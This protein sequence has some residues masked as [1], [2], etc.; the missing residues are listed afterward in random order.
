MFADVVLRVA[1]DGEVST[2]VEVEQ[3]SGLGWLPDG[4][5]LI[6]SMTQRRVLRYD[7]TSLTEHADVRA[8]A[9]QEINDMVVDRHGNA[10]L[11]QFGFD[12]LAGEAPIPADLIRIGAKGA[13]SLAATD[14]NFANGMAITADGSTLLVAESMA[15]RITAFT[16]SEDGVLT[17]RRIFADVA[18]FP[19]GITVDRDGGVWFGNPVSKEFVRVREG[20][21]ITDTIDTPGPHGI[22]CTLGG[23]DGRTL[24]ML[25]SSTLGNREQA[26]S[27]LG[28]SALTATVAVSVA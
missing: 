8:V 3:P 18:G 14:L 1:P 11:G 19:D 25:T 9:S 23:S 15:Q 21:E 13:V 7:G 5:L 12:P 17:D 16:L 10:F 24:F 2:V 22:A 28:A 4:T 27:T 26:I 20:G 6:S